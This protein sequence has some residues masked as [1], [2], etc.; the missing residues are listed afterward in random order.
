MCRRARVDGETAAGSTSKPLL[1]HNPA[2]AARVRR[3]RDAA[4]RALAVSILLA[5]LQTASSNPKHPGDTKTD[6][7]KLLKLKKGFSEK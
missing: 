2:D 6:Y 7:Y 1:P 3:R 5:A 4:M